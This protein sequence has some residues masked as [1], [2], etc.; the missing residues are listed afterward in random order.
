MFLFIEECFMA[1]TDAPVVDPLI[2]VDVSPKVP[3]PP[4]PLTARLEVTGVTKRT[5]GY[6]VELTQ[7]GGTSMGADPRGQLAPTSHTPNAVIELD[8]SDAAAVILRLG[9]KFDITFSK[10]D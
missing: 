4:P 6:S 3:P 1:K 2:D 5:T 7:I 8:I 10:V 9:L